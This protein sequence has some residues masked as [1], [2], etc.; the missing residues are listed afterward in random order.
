MRDITETGSG[1]KPIIFKL[2]KRN[3]KPALQGRYYPSIKRVPSEEI[4]FDPK[5]KSNRTIRYAPS[6]QSI[7]K[8][9][10]PIKVLLGDII[11]QNGS[12]VVSY[13]NPLLL[14]YLEH[15]NYNKDNS[16]RIRGN[17]AIFKVID[18]E[19]DARVTMDV[20]I[21]KIKAANAVLQMPFADLK[22]YGR[23][24]GVNTSN[25]SDMIRHDMLRLAKADPSKFMSGI[26]NPI[27]KRQQVILDAMEYKIIE[28][29]G[30]AVSW[31]LGDAKS[32]IITVPIGQ[33]SVEWLAE[34]TMNDK[35]GDEVFKELEKKIK[36]LVSE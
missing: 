28:L 20:E 13:T 22:A 32:L 11:F 5:T 24:L 21:E 34:W 29:S 15:S 30:R 8:D 3:P 19:A 10:Q 14:S 17:T 31:K 35:D 1:E 4:I 33:R 26:D 7:F 16:N 23:V 25:G 9:E 27:V 6:E 36:A 18:R 2:V 12:L